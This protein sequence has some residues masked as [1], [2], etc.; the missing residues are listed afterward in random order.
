M[1]GWD[2]FR[3]SERVSGI[4]MLVF[5][6][7]TILLFGGVFLLWRGLIILW[8]LRP[9]RRKKFVTVVTAKV[10][11]LTQEHRSA[12]MNTYYL[13]RFEYEQDGE[14]KAFSPKN[15]YRP[16]RLKLNSEVTLCI[17]EKGKFRTIRGNISLVKAAAFILIGAALVILQIFV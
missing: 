4:M 13:P 12:S 15:A 17:S 1:G 3:I 10:T 8:E 5:A 2:V 11:E 6:V 7:R 9:I 14:V 16:C